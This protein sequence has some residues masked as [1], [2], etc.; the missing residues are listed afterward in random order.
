MSKRK[1]EPFPP[2]PQRPI[3]CVIFNFVFAALF[4]WFGCIFYLWASNSEITDCV[5]N[6]SATTFY[7]IVVPPLVGVLLANLYTFKDT[8]P[9]QKTITIIL[10]VVAVMALLLATMQTI[11]CVALDHHN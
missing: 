10:I 3:G 4:L 7:C 6:S 9:K 5:N 2:P 8:T 11:L 1:S